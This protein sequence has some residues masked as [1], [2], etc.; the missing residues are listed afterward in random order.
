MGERDGHQNRPPSTQ[1]GVGDDLL[2]H[3]DPPKSLVLD[4]AQPRAVKVLE[5]E[6][7]QLLMCLSVCSKAHVTVSHSISWRTWLLM[8]CTGALCWVKTGWMARPRECWG[9]ELH[10]LAPGPWWGSPELSGGASPVLCPH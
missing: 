5:E 9:M 10:Q 6:L 4:R 3:L 8:A 2:S 7:V 1:E